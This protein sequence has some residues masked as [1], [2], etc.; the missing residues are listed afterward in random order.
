[1]CFFYSS[2]F[3]EKFYILPP[4]FFVGNIFQVRCLIVF[5]NLFSVLDG[6]VAQGVKNYKKGI[7]K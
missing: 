5:L 4:A 6:C 7:D 1:M 3:I 2:K